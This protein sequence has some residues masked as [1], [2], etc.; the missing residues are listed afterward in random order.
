ML[1]TIGKQI[2]EW[3]NG[4]FKTAVG[5]VLFEMTDEPDQFISLEL[6]YSPDDRHVSEVGRQA[7]CIDRPKIV[8]FRDQIL[9]ALVLLFLFYLFR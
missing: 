7:S 6:V 5:E 4:Q 1:V 3:S 2:Q 8:S 9:V